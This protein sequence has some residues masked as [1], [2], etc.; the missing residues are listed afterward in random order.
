MINEILSIIISSKM[1]LHASP[2]PKAIAFIQ[3]LSITRKV[4]KFPQKASLYLDIIIEVNEIGLKNS[5][6]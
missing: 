3:L 4:F 2:S 5:L 1:Q 6:S